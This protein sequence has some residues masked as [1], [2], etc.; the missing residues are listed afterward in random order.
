MSVVLS[1]H[2]GINHETTLFLLSA[3]VYF[4]NIYYI[5]FIFL[6]LELTDF[7]KKKKKTML[8]ICYLV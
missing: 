8:L 3:P 4:G 5:W 7:A 2:T 1:I 6:V